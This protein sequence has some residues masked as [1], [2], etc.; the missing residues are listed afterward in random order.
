[1]LKKIEAK[2][3]R[4]IYDGNY[5]LEVWQIEDIN[6]GRKFEFYLTSN[7]SIYKMYMYGMKQYQPAAQ[8][9]YTKTEM[10]KMALANVGDYIKDYEEESE[11]FEAMLNDILMKK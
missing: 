2:G 10:I 6:E 9:T 1:M 5:T 11:T 3:E 8:K 4:Y 7:E